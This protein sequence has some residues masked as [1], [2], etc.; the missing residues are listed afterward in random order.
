MAKRIAFISRSHLSQN[1]LGLVVATLP[2]KTEYQAF[3]DLSEAQGK[4]HGKNFTLVMVDLNAVNDIPK[5]D[6]QTFLSQRGF[7]NAKKILLHVRD[8]TLNPSEWTDLGFD[9][10]LTKPFLPQEFLTLVT[11]RSGGKS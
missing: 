2:Q 6:V 3:D 1:L 5:M 11:K 7:R 9:F 4:N 10:F 8:R